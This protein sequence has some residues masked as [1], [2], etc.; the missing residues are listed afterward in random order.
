MP[1]MHTT[2]GLLR[3]TLAHN[4]AASFVTVHSWTCG[5]AQRSASVAMRALSSASIPAEPIQ[6]RVMG[7][8][9][10]HASSASPMRRV[11]ARSDRTEKRPAPMRER[12]TIRPRAS[13]MAA[14]VDVPPAST[15]ATTP[16]MGGGLLG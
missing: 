12:A 2:Q 9:F 13:A 15:T 4:K 16:V 7:A 8:S 1:A 14:R 6:A 5:M 11:H 3:G 10:A